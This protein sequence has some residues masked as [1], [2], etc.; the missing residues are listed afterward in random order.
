MIS[1]DNETVFGCLFFCRLKWRFDS[2]VDSAG[3]H[4]HLFIPVFMRLFYTSLLCV[5]AFINFP[6]ILL[7]QR[8]QMHSQLHIRHDCHFHLSLLRLIL[9]KRKD[10]F[11]DIK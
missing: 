10:F 2:T 9:N 4:G 11:S 5:L 7:V 8:I 3:C 6:V 1:T